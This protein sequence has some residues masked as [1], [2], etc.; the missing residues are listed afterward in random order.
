MPVGQNSSIGRGRCQ[1]CAIRHQAVCGALK[2]DELTRLNQIARHRNFA[3]GQIVMSDDDR[4]EFFANVVSGVV[5]LAKTMPDGRQQIVGLLFAPDFVGR[6]YSE[7]NPYFAEAATAVELCCFPRDSFESLLREFPGLEHRLFERTLNELDSAREWM[8]LLGRKTAQEKVASFLLLLADHIGKPSP[9]N[10]A[11]SEF[12]LPLKRADI[13]DFLGLTLETVSRQM[14][15]L[16]KMG[17]I[18]IRK[19]L[20]V[21]VQDTDRL[22]T[23]SGG[24]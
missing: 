21:T 24:D 22:I 17:A 14:T 20:E 11:H 23:I 3:P 8:V 5:K 6:A 4:A 10:P 18:D 15:K 1:T 7:N 2:D 16:R 12:M 19:N 9:D 13:A